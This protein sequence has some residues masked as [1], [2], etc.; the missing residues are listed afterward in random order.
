MISCQVVILG[1]SHDSGH[2]LCLKAQGEACPFFAV[3]RMIYGREFDGVP[4]S[5]SGRVLGV[6][7]NQKLSLQPLTASRDAVAKTP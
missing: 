5:R 3:S 2:G 7:V 6:F 1:E 4:D